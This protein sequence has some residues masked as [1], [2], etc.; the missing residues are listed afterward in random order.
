[1][2]HRL[3]H[4]LSFVAALLLAVPAAAGQT[5]IAAG[6]AFMI[7]GEQTT[8]IAINGR[9]VG[10]V[11]IAIEAE[12]QGMRVF[13]RT[14]APGQDFEQVLGSGQTGVFRNPSKK[15]G[16]AVEFMLGDDAKALAMRYLLPQDK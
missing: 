9:N 12:V 11:P 13:L 1:M 14:I 15:A 3:R 4:T 16:A 10:R 7:G 2:R 6:D 8:P 5:L